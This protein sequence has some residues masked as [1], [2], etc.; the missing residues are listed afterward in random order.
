MWD[1]SLQPNCAGCVGCT[2]FG[3]QCPNCDYNG[4]MG[5]ECGHYVNLS[6]PYFTMVACGFAGGAPSSGDGWSVQ[7][8]E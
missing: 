3:G 6:A 2:Q 5:N 4:T 8:Y 7:N 1:E